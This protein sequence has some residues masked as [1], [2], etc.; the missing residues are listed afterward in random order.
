MNCFYEIVKTTFPLAKWIPALV[1]LWGTIHMLSYRNLPLY[2]TQHE[3]FIV[4]DRGSHGS[5]TE[6]GAYLKISDQ[7]KPSHVQK[8]LINST[9]WLDKL[10]NPKKPFLCGLGIETHC[11]MQQVAEVIE[12]LWGVCQFTLLTKA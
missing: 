12:S 4:D 8:Y 11:D 3:A 1:L 2:P 6:N 7:G 5:S 9:V 10:R